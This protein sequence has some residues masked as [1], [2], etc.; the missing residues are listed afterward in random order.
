ME[1]GMTV[2][3]SIIDEIEVPIGISIDIKEM[4]TILGNIELIPESLSSRTIDC[5]NIGIDMF[6][7]TPVSIMPNDIEYIGD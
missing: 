1:D 5:I 3:N 6:L 4:R 7:D 2:D